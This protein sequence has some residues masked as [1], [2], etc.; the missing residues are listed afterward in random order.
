VDVRGDGGYVVVPVS[1]H[2]SGTTYEWVGSPSEPLAELPQAMLALLKGRGPQRSNALGGVAIPE[3]QR[4]DTLY[5][6]AR[7]MKCG[8]WSLDAIEAALLAENQARCVP[9]LEKDE[10]RA[11]AR[12]AFTQP[13]REDFQFNRSF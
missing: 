12:R 6:R 10:L 2:S 9:P 7:S 3:G 8:G 1:C 11:I 13:D 4:N 5:R